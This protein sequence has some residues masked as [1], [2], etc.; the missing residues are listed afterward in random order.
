MSELK[1]EC[2]ECGY[3]NPRMGAKRYKCGGSKCPGFNWTPK[4][5]EKALRR[6]YRG[7]A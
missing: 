4:Q 2:F 6:G 3:F 7:N 5:K 1:K